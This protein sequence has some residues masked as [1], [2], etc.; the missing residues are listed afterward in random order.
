MECA[1][2]HLYPLLA[3]RPRPLTG[4]LRAGLVEP[5]DPGDDENNT[6]SSS[7][8]QRLTQSS[9]AG[10]PSAAGSSPFSSL[11]SPQKLGLLLGAG[12]TGRLGLSSSVGKSVSLM[13]GTFS[14]L[15]SC[16]T[17]ESELCS[18][19]MLLLRRFCRFPMYRSIS[20]ISSQ[21][22]ACGNA[23]QG[24]PGFSRRC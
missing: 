8:G 15:G 9:W 16:G 10:T 11:S 18:T 23:R 14:G 21:A 20:G 22:L 17:A 2:A 13:P 7:R 19:C 4:V 24:S 3:L 1:L 6:R 5:Q 12:V